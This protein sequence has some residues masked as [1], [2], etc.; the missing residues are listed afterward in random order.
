[1]DSRPNFGYDFELRYNRV[2]QHCLR[3]LASDVEVVPL[4]TKL[5]KWETA[6]GQMGSIPADLGVGK[7]AQVCA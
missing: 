1:M 6:V 7:D 5:A 3:A 4:Q 2:L